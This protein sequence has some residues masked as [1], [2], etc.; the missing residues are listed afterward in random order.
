MNFLTIL[1]VILAII[2]LLLIRIKK[3]LDR[4]IDERYPEEATPGWM[5]ATFRPWY[6]H[7]NKIIAV[8]TVGTIFTLIFG[9]YGFAYGAYDLGNQQNYA[10]EQP[11]KFSHQ[12]HAGTY[13]MD[14][15]YCHST[16]SKSKNAS[17]P[18]VG[19]CM[20]CHVYVQATEKYNGQISPEIQKIYKA[21]DFNPETG[22]YGKNPQ[23]VKWIRIHNLPDLAYFNHSQHVAVGKVECQTCHGPIETMAVVQQYSTLQM[24]WCIDCHRNN[25]I[26][27]ENNKYYE[28][29]HKKLKK[30]EKVTVANNGGLECSKCHY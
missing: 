5:V 21:A 15:Q 26:D 8:L 17:I 25:N 22:K 10:P 23:P 2:V 30:G 20:N 6:A 3:V 12:I 16:A 19:T 4:L 14:C 11:I 27:V 7:L 29:L 28:D 9:L 1:S 13:K 18:P 24:G